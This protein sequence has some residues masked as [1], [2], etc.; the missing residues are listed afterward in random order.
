VPIHAGTN[1]AGAARDEAD[2]A[3]RVRRF[4]LSGDVADLW[5]GVT[6]AA[7]AEARAEIE[8]VTTVLLRQTNPA[9]VELS[10]SDHQARVFSCA[11]FASGTG[12]LLGFWIEQHRV[13]AP[14][15]LAAMLLEQLSQNR[16]FIARVD[17]ELAPALDAFAA[18]EIVPLVIKGAHTARAYWDDV[19]VR[20]IA[21]VDLV[22]PAPR[23]ADAERA[24]AEAGFAPGGAGLQEPYK[25]DWMP[26][27]A[28]TPASIERPDA[29]NP[30][31]IDLH[32]SLDQ[33]F[34]CGASAR[35]D[36]TL[37]DTR[38]LTL[39]GRRVLAP[40][41]PLTLLLLATH[42]ARHLDSMRLFRIIEL[43]EVIR[44]DTRARRLDWD[45]VVD[46]L[47]VTQSAA[48]A[49][50]LLHLAEQLVPGTVDERVRQHCASAATWGVRHTVRRMIPSG[51]SSRH[52]LVREFMW[53]RGPIDLSRRVVAR[54]LA[55]DSL[56]VRQRWLRL[57]RRALDGLISI[58]AP[59]ERAITSSG[60]RAS[61]S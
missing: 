59:D 27:G 58:R 22:I 32:V 57:A 43:V 30:W 13:T 25:R 14:A 61:R 31:Q 4:Q 55:R 33:D 54:V 19:G 1:D 8:R 36:R 50:P 18:M 12:A 11:A 29:R 48:Y 60:V 35:L 56:G 6:A 46:A 15:R 16:Q 3:S 10:A 2:I 44:R 53:A 42:A 26:P 20:P 49:F 40:E 7:V 51:S 24:L 41:Q 28:R 37:G 34:G 45:R 47:H 5:P 39:A 21:D 52:G 38:D 17:G 23:V 9:P